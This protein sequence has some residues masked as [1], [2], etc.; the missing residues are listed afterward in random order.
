MSNQD[1]SDSNSRTQKSMPVSGMEMA[2]ER[3]AFF[4]GGVSCRS[5]GNAEQKLPVPRIH[6]D[7]PKRVRIKKLLVQPLDIILGSAFQRGD[8]HCHF[9]EIANGFDP[10]SN[11]WCDIVPANLDQ[12]VAGFCDLNR[13][14][15][16]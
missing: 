10:D 3:Q 8:I 2:K 16:Q 1:R 11:R 12:Q 6:S 4:T 14:I 9:I 15:G 13:L 5:S 7:T